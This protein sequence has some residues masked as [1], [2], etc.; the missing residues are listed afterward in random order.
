MSK[1]KTRVIHGIKLASWHPAQRLGTTA[2]GLETGR[3]LG[4]RFGARFSTNRNE[5]ACKNCNR[6]LSSQ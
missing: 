6:C 4:V 2:C 1:D 5:V 3:V